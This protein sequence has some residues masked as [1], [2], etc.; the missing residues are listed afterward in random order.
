MANSPLA[1]QYFERRWHY[2]IIFK[3]IFQEEESR[4]LDFF[5]TSNRTCSPCTTNKAHQIMPQS[6]GITLYTNAISKNWEISDL[7]YTPAPTLDTLDTFS[8]WW[9]EMGNSRHES[10]SVVI[11]NRSEKRPLFSTQ[12]KASSN[13]MFLNSGYLNLD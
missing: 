8:S 1:W 4:R 10:S 3:H 11:S 12:H 6:V 7:L 2:F 13:M 9:R 5:E